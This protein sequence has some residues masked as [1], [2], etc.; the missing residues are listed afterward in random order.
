MSKDEQLILQVLEDYKTAVFTKNVAAFTALYDPTVCVFDMW[1]VWAYRGLDAWRG[2]VTDWFGSLG[3]ER[4]AVEWHDVQTA[5]TPEMAVVHAFVTYKG[6]SAAGEAL[7][8]MQNRITMVLKHQE[9][10]WKIIHEHSSAPADFETAKVML[11][12]CGE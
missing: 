9:A 6:V 4:V 5:V 12:S 3:D 8:A 2:M 1:G 10:G 11:H 7:R